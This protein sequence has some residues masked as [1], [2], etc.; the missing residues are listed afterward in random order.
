M[1]KNPN[2]GISP[3]SLSL[4]TLGLHF[5]LIGWLQSCMNQK[6][7]HQSTMPNPQYWCS[8]VSTSELKCEQST[9]LHPVPGVFRITS[10]HLYTSTAWCAGIEAISSHYHTNWVSFPL[11]LR[12][13]KTFPHEPLPCTFPRHWV[14]RCSKIFGNL[15]G[16]QIQ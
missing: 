9:R 7:K 5:I 15:I 1:L 8:A 12:S 14:N 2:K 3:I 11:V 10:N 13:I 4:Q 6:R 16:V